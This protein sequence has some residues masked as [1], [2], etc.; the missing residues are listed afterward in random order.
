MTD[1]ELKEL[2]ADLLISQ[3]ENLAFQ[4]ETNAA[5]KETRAS[6]KETNA[7][8][9]ELRASQR[10]TDRQM[11]ETDRQMKETD[12]KM[13]ETDR[14]MKETDL[15]IKELGRQIGGLGRKF[16]GFT[17]GMAYPSMKRLLRKR[18]HMETIT[19]R[20]EISRN[21]KHMELDVLGYSNGKG[22][23]VVVVEVK[24]RLTPEGID[25]MEQTMTRFDEFFPEHRD[26]RR[27]GMIAAVDFSPNVEFQTQRRG[28]YL[29]RIQDELFVLRSPESF[30]PRYFGGV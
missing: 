24:S 9:R 6:I 19:P 26:K 17:E 2:V 21:G 18:F 5:I 12:R 29:A 8:I 1:E 10:E 23:Q 30:Q 3:R 28:F 27:F 7:G 13:K 16:G 15:Q 25:Q 20:V 22:N 11:K 14:Q 4:K